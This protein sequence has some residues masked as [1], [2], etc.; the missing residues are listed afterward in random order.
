MDHPLHSESNIIRFLLFK[1][2]Y[3][4]EKNVDTF[5]SFQNKSSHISTYTKKI[6]IILD[7]PLPD[8]YKSI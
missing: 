8:C 7:S 4:H 2:G 3:F 6:N 5:H 1:I